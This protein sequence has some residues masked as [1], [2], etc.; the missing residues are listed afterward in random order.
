[1]TKNLNE[2][3]FV[4]KLKKLLAFMISCNL[5]HTRMIT[6]LIFLRNNNETEISSIRPVTIL[7][8]AIFQV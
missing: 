6:T 4:R 3:L 1:M 5:I 8:L 7:F 2:T